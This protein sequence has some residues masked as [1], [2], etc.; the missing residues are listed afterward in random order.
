MRFIVSR[1]EPSATVVLVGHDS[2]NR[3]LLCVALGLSLSRYWRL[4]QEPCA[5]NLLEFGDDDF[6]VRLVNGT[7]HLRQVDTG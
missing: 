5:L 6:V 4:R 3:A 7:G 1:H 2:V